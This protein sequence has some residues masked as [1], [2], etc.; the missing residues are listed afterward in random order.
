MAEAD[1]SA[2]A[3]ISDDGWQ[4]FPGVWVPGEIL[5]MPVSQAWVQGMQVIV[6]DGDGAS[7]TSMPASGKSVMLLH[8]G[9]YRDRL[10][11]RDVWLAAL[12]ARA[13]GAT[14]Y[15]P[16]YP[17][18]SDGYGWSD[19]YQPVIDLYGRIVAGGDGSDVTVIG[20]SSGG[21]LAVGLCE[22]ASSYG[23]PQPAMLEL[24]SPWVDISVQPWDGL[25]DAAAAWAGGWGVALRDPAVSPIYGD[26]SRL[27]RVTIYDG[28]QDGLSGSIEG[29]HY[30]LRGRNV[31]S[32][33]V[34]E[35]EMGHCY[36]YLLP[37][38]EASAALSLMCAGI[39]GEALPMSDDGWIFP[40]QGDEADADGAA[41]STHGKVTRSPRSIEDRET[42]DWL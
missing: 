33:L 24:V 18:S 35:R 15:V 21:G 30:Q 23:I 19:A 22:V 10:P 41:A 11:M 7:T 3:R 13:T 34:M 39:S 37:R 6:I 32:T 40:G 25:A 17:V 14:A 4:E 27:G 38:S 16:A 9:A 29:F 5:G 36:P 31:D 2:T 26:V 8:G 20:V 12:V 28:G 1:A 42:S